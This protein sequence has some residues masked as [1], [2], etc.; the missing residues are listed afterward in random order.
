MTSSG[1]AQTVTLVGRA[2]SGTDTLGNDVFAETSTDSP[3]IFAPGGSTEQ[4]QGQ[5][6][7]TDQPAV[8]LPTGTSVAVIDA[9]VVGGQRFEVD[10]EPNIW[11][12][13]PFTGWQP[14]YSVQVKLRRVTG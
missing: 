2:K 10:G 7:V 1:F 14:E 6:V 13:N 9:V 5:D 11:P 4:L 8:F 3:G 12:P